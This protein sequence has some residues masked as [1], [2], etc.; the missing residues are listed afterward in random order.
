MNIRRATTADAGLLAEVMKRTFDLEM[1]RWATE[2]NEYDNNLRPPGYDSAEMHKYFIRESDYFVLEV[3]Q[4]IAGGF[5][6][7]YTG[8]RHARLDKIFIDPQYQ[9]RGFGSKIMSFLEE[10]FP[11]VRVWKLETSSKQLSNHHFYEKAGYTRIY[12]S[13]TEFGYE[14]VKSGTAVTAEEGVRFEDQQLSKAEF[15]NCM[16]NEADFYNMN[17]EKSSYSNSNLRRSLFTD[18][19]MS[20]SKFTNLNLQSTLIADS[21]LTGST[22]FGCDLSNVNIQECNLSGLRI[23]DIPVED[24]F[25]AFRFLTGRE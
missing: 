8:R 18:C 10:E 5:S 2:E 1:K 14:K 17:L 22:L 16:M 21:R 12:E 9:G 3:E 19:N 6:I 25:A 4:H 7:N 24:L 11:A 20:D 13:A 15:E 23:H